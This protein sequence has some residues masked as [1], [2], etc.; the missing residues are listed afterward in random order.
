[1]RVSGW[2][3]KRTCLALDH[4][5]DEG[6]VDH[7]ACRKGEE[8]RQVCSGWRVSRRGESVPEEKAREAARKD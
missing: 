8:L 4:D 2:K 3:G 1:M 6:N 7:D 5:G